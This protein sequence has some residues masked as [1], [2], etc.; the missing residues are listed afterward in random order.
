[1]SPFI[2][3]LVTACNPTFGWIENQITHGRKVG[4]VGK[5]SQLL[6]DMFNNPGKITSK[7]TINIWLAVV[8]GTEVNARNEPI[9][10]LV[11]PESLSDMSNF[12]CNLWTWAWYESPVLPNLK[13]WHYRYHSDGSLTITQQFGEGN[14]TFN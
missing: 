13:I 4:L 1:M 8:D 10:Q 11:W 2:D 6:M 14:C 9:L 12:E 5:D 7:W 3:F